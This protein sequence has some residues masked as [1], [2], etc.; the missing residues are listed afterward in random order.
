MKPDMDKII[1]ELIKNMEDSMDHDDYDVFGKLNEKS[2]RNQLTIAFSRVRRMVLDEAIAKVKTIQWPEN[3][4]VNGRS[5][6]F[7]YKEAVKEIMSCLI[8]LKSKPKH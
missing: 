7:G 4:L 6:P 3:R 8:A 1:E 5:A 2:W